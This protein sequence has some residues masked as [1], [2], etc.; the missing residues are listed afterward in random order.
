MAW[1]VNQ[2]TDHRHTVCLPHR[3]APVLQGLGE[4]SHDFYIS[5]KMRAPGV[6]PARY[7]NR[8]TVR[9]PMV[10]GKSV[11]RRLDCRESCLAQMP[12]AIDWTGACKKAQ[13]RIERMASLKTTTP[14][15]VKRP[16]PQATKST[17]ASGSSAWPVSFLPG[18][19]KTP[20]SVSFSSSRLR[21]F[22]AAVSCFTTDG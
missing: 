19:D 1:L 12:Q 8:P 17:A 3:Y 21:G 10:G 6:A 9:P 16:M 22:L 2:G 11:T 15:P 20:D 18:P 14:A 5:E 4:D 7:L 13:W